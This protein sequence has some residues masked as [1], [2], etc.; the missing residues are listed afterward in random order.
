M[1]ENKLVD[2]SMDLSVKA[3]KTIKG[4]YPLV[5]QLEGSATSIGANINAMKPK[6]GWCF[7]SRRNYQA[8]KLPNRYT[9]NAERFEEF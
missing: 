7:L 9:I 4:H 5:N 3:I 1:L 8:E 2:L 6:I